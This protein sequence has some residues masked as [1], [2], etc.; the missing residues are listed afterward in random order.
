MKKLLI[1][2]SFFLTLFA[3]PAFAGNEITITCSSSGCTKSSNLPIFDEQNIY[4]G[5]TFSQTFFV[6]NNRNG[7]CNLTLK[8]I[9]TSS[10]D[11]LSQKLLI[12]IV[13]TNNSNSLNI[14]NYLLSDLVDPTKPNLSLGHVNKNKKNSYLW[15][16]YFDA[17]ADNDYQNLSANFSVNFN[18]ECDEEVGD[19]PVNISY[20]PPSTQTTPQCTNSVPVAPTGFYGVRNPSGSV[21]L[22]WQNTPSEHTGY[23]I[24]YGTSPGIY[25]YGAPD[26]GDVESYTV[27]GLTFGAQYCFYVRSLNG[28]MPGERTPEYCV[29]PGSTVIP[30][31]VI[32]PGFEPEVLGVDT[33]TENQ[34][35]E[36]TPQFLNGDVL[37]SLDKT[38]KQH[39]LPLLYLLALFVNL[40]LIR[41]S[42]IK[43]LVISTLVSL[44]AY[45]IDS[46]LL[47][48]RCCLWSDW[49]CH[50]FWIGC[51]FSWLAPLTIK[52]FNNPK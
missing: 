36:T 50:Y 7:T 13:G 2:I 18:F 51:I 52:G 5:Q 43:Y 46:Y 15:S 33:E 39:W 21:T 31:D 48:S 9:S 3:K 41:K 47:K 6:D 49:F 8:G 38:C 4:P 37:G 28:C 27:Q 24:A 32:P 10:P 12:S 40:L 34:P 11:V 26:V 23:L 20:N 45:L 25:Q 17:S 14:S 44:S 29:N 16:T 22:R 19:D 30:A 1:S 42:L 35:T